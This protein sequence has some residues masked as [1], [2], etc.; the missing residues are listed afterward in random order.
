M[1]KYFILFCVPTGTMATW[2]ETT[3]PEERKKQSD[4]M[5]QEWGGW[6]EKMGSALTDKG[7]PLGKT[8]RVTKA[9]AADVKNDLNYY[10]ILEA[11]SHEAAAE[12]VKSSPHLQIPDAYIEVI[13]ISHKGM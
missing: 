2:M 9:G 4:Q 8:K 6:M 13:E 12:M 5:M 7:L 11:E 10:V 1:K 3:T